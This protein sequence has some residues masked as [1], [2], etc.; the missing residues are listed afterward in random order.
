MHAYI[1]PSLATLMLQLP[2]HPP[3][4]DVLDTLSGGVHIG[5]VNMF[6]FATLDEGCMDYS[7]D[8][9]PKHLRKLHMGR[10]LIMHNAP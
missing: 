1:P 5:Q 7:E 6:F 2:T 4:P 10:R 3:E 9:S 8:M